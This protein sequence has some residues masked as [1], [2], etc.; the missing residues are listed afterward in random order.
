MG[1][2]RLRPLT[3]GAA[4]Y[5]LGAANG[6]TPV[7]VGGTEVIGVT[8]TATFNQSAGSN[9][10]IGGGTITGTNQ[11]YN[12]HYGTLILGAIGGYQAF[13]SN[14]VFYGNAVGTY[15]LSGGF[16]GGDPSVADQG[17]E[18]IGS[19]GGTGI[20]TQTG[21]VN[22]PTYHFFVG[23]SA[24]YQPYS[25]LNHWDST[26]SFGRYSLQGGLFNPIPSETENIGTSGTG[27][28]TQSA[29]S[30]VTSGILLGGAANVYDSL[31]NQTQIYTSGTYTLN[32]GLLQTASINV[33]SILTGY[34]VG[35]SLPPPVSCAN[36]VINAGTLQAMPMTIAGTT[37]KNALP[38]TVGT[39]AS[40]VAT[41]DANGQTM[42]INGSD[43]YM[44]SFLGPGQL[45]VIDSAGGGTVV[46]GGTYWNG[47]GPSD[48]SNN[49]TG[50][51]TV[52][53]G[54][55]QVLNAQALPT[56]GVLT[57]GGPASVVMSGAVGTMFGSGAV[58][59]AAALGGAGVEI[60]PFPT[61]AETGASP[62]AVVAS[63]VA[64]FPWEAV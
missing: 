5:N 61:G 26:S 57:V 16:L 48:I 58:E 55:L 15:N 50:G 30:N 47:R 19:L 14:A 23:G 38:V 34:F 41:I 11:G 31:G 33:N 40:C 21:G 3:H 35:L 49:Y 4:T 8:G 32:G 22:A 10:L 29:G 62:T 9:I 46:L 24:G 36:F 64:Q 2:L 39:D 20:F 42:P 51:T 60:A 6:N 28:F 45:Q 25:P 56:I 43:S 59:Q 63:G 44:G 17:G 37:F 7:L 12:N 54:T 13:G 1:A 18:M 53:S 52:L 27:I